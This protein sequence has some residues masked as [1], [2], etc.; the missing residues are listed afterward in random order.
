MTLLILLPSYQR[1]IEPAQ[2]VVVC[3][4]VDTA[5][6]LMEARAPPPRRTLPSSPHSSLAQ[7]QHTLGHFRFTLTR[8]HSDPISGL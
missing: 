3:D 2:D 5:E 1:E 8:L 7:A 4:L 6:N